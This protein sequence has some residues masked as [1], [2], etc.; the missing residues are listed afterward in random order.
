VFEKLINSQRIISDTVCKLVYLNFPLALQMLA[1]LQRE[2]PTLV[3][4]VAQ[5]EK[6][7]MVDGY[8]SPHEKR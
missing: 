7:D 6:G 8:I 5:L 2:D 1:Q 3:G 4:I